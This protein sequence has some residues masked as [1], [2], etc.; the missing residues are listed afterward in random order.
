MS[1]KKIILILF[2]I[3]LVILFIM[4]G[5]LSYLK[6][7][8]LANLVSGTYLAPVEN[9]DYTLEGDERYIAEH[10]AQAHEHFANRPQFFQRLI[11]ITPV[12]ENSVNI[13]VYVANEKGD[14]FEHCYSNLT[15]FTNIKN[16]Y[17]YQFNS[18]KLPIYFDDKEEHFLSSVLL[19]EKNR[20]KIAIHLPSYEPYNDDELSHKISGFS[21]SYTHNYTR[22]EDPKTFEEWKQIVHEQLQQAV[23]DQKKRKAKVLQ[24]L[25][26]TQ[27]YYDAF[28]R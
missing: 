20:D 7:I 3:L 25:K 26:N 22:Q 12:N 9:Y 18:E 16:L 5:F 1:K 15:L 14:T 13:H 6:S 19:I 17:E 2:S 21:A 23:D 28:M 10:G 8:N 11:E 27:E 24:D 4:G